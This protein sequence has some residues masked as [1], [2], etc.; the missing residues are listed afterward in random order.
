MEIENGD[1]ADA[2]SGKH[3]SVLIGE[4]EWDLTDNEGEQFVT[5]TRK[6]EDETVSVRFSIADFPAPYSEEDADEALLDEEDF[7]A[8]SG[9]ANTKG[10]VNQG[11]TSGG[12][13]KIAPEDS[14]APADR[15]E[16]RDSEVRT[17]DW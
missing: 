7:D 10:A 11:R 16:L 14:V 6:Y 8:Q 3:D 9:G 2:E 12:N 4:R 5:F 1:E 15:D 13:V 17:P